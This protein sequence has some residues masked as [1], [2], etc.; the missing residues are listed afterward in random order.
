MLNIFK[1]LFNYYLLFILI[2]FIGRLGLFIIY[3]DD[4]QN[5]QANIWLSF[6]YGLKIDTML[7]SILLTIPMVLLTLTPKLF[8]TYVNAFLKYYFLLIISLAIYIEIATFPFIFQYDFRPNYLFVEYLEY[9]KEVFSMIIADYKIALFFAF[10]IISLFI[11]G[12]LKRF[13]NGFKDCFE[14]TYLKRI[15][16]FIPLFI[17]LL[18]GARSSFGHRPA[19]ISDAM[20]SNNRILNEITKNSIYSIG[21]AIYSTKEHSSKDIEK[22]YGKM[23]IK[24]A[25]RRVQKELNI[26][27]SNKKYFMQHFDK[28]NF[29]TKDTKNIVIFIQES[30]GYQ[31]VEAVGGEKGLTPNLNK[32][33]KDGIL[34]T[35]LYSNGTRSVRGLA[36]LSAGNF[37]IPGK[38][39]IKRNK[40]QSDYFT[41]AKLLKP[42]GYHTSFI[43]GGESRFDNMKSWYLGNSFDEV[44]DEESFKSPSFVGTWGVCDEDV[45]IKANETYK[46]L[47][48]NHKKF[49]SIIFS[50]SNH[51]P[52]DFPDNKI[53]LVKN[54]EKKSV[55]NAVKY[56][57][58]AIGKFIQ[59]AKKENYYKDTIF[60]IVADHNVRVYGNEIIPINMFQIPGLI[61]GKKIKPTTYNKLSTQPDILATVIDLAGI[62]STSPIMGHSIFNKDKQDIAFM[63]FNNRYALRIK[64]KIAIIRPNKKALTFKYEQKHLKQIDSDIELE[65]NTLAFVTVLNNLYKD[66]LY[67]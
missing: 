47:Y 66:K 25:I 46:N 3:F 14:T 40:S 44:I 28:T 6:I 26:K 38:G 8:E 24:E 2:F 54:V 56:A 17:I 11:Y 36:G 13:N 9:P 19:N 37:S 39:V 5:T 57:D 18:M 50:T 21:Y 34:F 45:V 59:M 52:F 33:S 4:F 12:Y 16:L 32:L 27:D 42:L 63:Q 35:K 58:Y 15:L 43:Y 67:Q 20:F 41:I 48:N 7:T 53:E 31:F 60:A 62:S 55:K 10:S 29:D 1:K 22:I 23:D 61:L 30:L 65:K 49:A 64:N 51:T